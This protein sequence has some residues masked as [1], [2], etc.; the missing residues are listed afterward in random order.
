MIDSGRRTEHGGLGGAMRPPLMDARRYGVSAPLRW[1]RSPSS[2]FLVSTKNLCRGQ[3][4][5]SYDDR[6]SVATFLGAESCPCFGRVTMNNPGSS[7]REAQ[8]LTTNSAAAEFVAG[9]RRRSIL[10][11]PA[12]G[13]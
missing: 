2:P 6:F 8:R 10:W 3:R 7:P 4:V 12:R 5:P 13:R 1:T 11:R 9:Q